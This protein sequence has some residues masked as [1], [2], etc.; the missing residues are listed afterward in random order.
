MQLGQSIQHE[1]EGFD[2]VTGMYVPTPCYF[3]RPNWR[4]VLD[5]ISTN[6]PGSRVGVFVC[7]PPPMAG[8]LKGLCN[9]KNEQGR[10]L[11][12]AT[13]YVFHKENF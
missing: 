4:G 9:R 3:G 7:G 8:E 2:P 13:K 6:H 5:K 12:T 1:A 10:G 11:E